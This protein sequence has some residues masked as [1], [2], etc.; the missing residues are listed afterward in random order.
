MSPADDQP[1]VSADAPVAA[2]PPFKPLPQKAPDV[3]IEKTADGTYYVR[4]NHPPAQG[5]RSIAHLLAER[6]AAHPD[7]PYIL[8]RA[9]GHGPWR[10]VTYGEAKRAADA[11]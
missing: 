3:S 11:I 7:R 9:P 5:P 2:P 4:S 1:A 10:G 8:Q 6:A